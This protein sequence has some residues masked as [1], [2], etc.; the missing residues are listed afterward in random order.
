MPESSWIP[1][2]EWARIQR[3]L[4]ITCVDVLPVRP[5]NGGVEAGLILRDTPDGRRWCL[6][7]GRILHNESIREAILRQLT[8]TLGD[9]VRCS[10]DDHPKP[11]HVAEYF[12]ERRAG[13]LHDPRQHALGLSFIVVVSGPIEAKGEAIEFRWFRPGELPPSDDFG[14][15]QRVVVEALLERL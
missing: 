5:V 1:E 2:E 14:F 7:G 11:E 13:E 8:S 12:S 6:I 15:G 10:L 4:P 9:G 3:L